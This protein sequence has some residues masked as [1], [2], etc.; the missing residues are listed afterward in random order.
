MASNHGCDGSLA[1][2][3]FAPRVP[4]RLEYQ[5]PRSRH[6]AAVH[7]VDGGVAHATRSAQTTATGAQ[8]HHPRHVSDFLGR[9]WA[10]RSR[11]LLNFRARQ[12]RSHLKNR[13]HR[14]EPYKQK[15]QR[16]EETD[17]ADEHGPIPHRRLVH[18]PRRRQVIAMQ[19]RHDDD[20]ALE[21]HTDAHDERNDPQR[22]QVRT[23]FFPPQELRRDDVAENQRP[24]IQAVRTMHAVPYHEPL[25]PVAAVPAE[26]RFHDVAVTDN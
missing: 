3:P 22:E 13:N 1:R 15:Q 26:E 7:G 14:Q 18:T 6:K 19:A 11:L 17:G 2:K 16:K 10:Y 12:N 20:E 25:I 8:A 5:T 4:D 9:R 21:P 23:Y 24:V